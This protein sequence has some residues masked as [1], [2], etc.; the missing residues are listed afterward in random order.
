MSSNVTPLAH[1][2][3]GWQS[4]DGAGA[5]HFRMRHDGGSILCVV[6]RAVLLTLP[7]IVPTSGEEDI[8]K[9][10]EPHLARFEAIAN[11]KYVEGGAEDGKIVLDEVD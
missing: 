11:A 3:E 8:F 2:E 4:I 9:A 1:D 10:F 6:P 7:G 5:L